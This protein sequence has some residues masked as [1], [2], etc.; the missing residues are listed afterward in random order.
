MNKLL[1]ALL[2]TVTVLGT[3]GAVATLLPSAAASYPNILGYRSVCTFAPA[4]SLCRRP[5]S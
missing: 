4:A 1:Y 5:L 3:A 2:L